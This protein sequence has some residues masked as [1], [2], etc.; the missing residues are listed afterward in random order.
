MVNEQGADG[1]Q[2]AIFESFATSPGSLASSV[3]RH[4]G[5]DRGDPAR[6]IM[7]RSLEHCPLE[8]P[9]CF[10][11]PSREAFSE[12]QSSERAIQSTQIGLVQ[13]I[14]WSTWTTRTQ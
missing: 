8:N 14:S 10:Q 7:R 3:D 13:A 5:L 9:A 11:R 12:S 1:Q 4:D 6:S 2:G